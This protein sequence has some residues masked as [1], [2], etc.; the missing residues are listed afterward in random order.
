MHSGRES[1]CRLKSDCSYSHK[2]TTNKLEGKLGTKL[3]ALEKLLSEMALNVK[4]LEIKLKEVEN[5]PVP[6]ENIEEK[7]LEEQSTEVFQVIKKKTNRNTTEEKKN[8][9]V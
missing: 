6:V 4:S 3:N 5:V 2:D 9:G 8:I 1:N 7:K